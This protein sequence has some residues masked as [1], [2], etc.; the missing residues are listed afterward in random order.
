MKR[1]IVTSFAVVL[2][3]VAFQSCQKESVVGKIDPEAQKAGIM[4]VKAGEPETK[5]YIFENGTI[6]GKTAYDLKWSA[7]DAIGCYE[8]ST[9]SGT[10]TIQTTRVTSSPLADDAS[11][12]TFTMNFSGNSGEANFSYIFVYP[13]ASY[14]VKNEANGT[15][16]GIIPQKQTFALNSFDKNADL[17]ISEPIMNQ[18]S[19]PTDVSA[20]FERIGSTVLMNI[21]APG[22]SEKIRKITF[23]TSEENIKLQGYY[24]IRPLDGEY[25]IAPYSGSKSIELTPATETIYTGTIP[26]W[27]RCSETTLSNNFTVVVT[28]NKKIY[29]KTVDLASVSRQLAFENAGLTKFNVDMESVVGEDNPYLDDDDYIIVA[30]SGA[31]FYALTNTDDGSGKTRL[32]YSTLTD[33]DPTASAYYTDNNSIVW[34]LANGADN[35]TLQDNADNYLNQGD[36]KASVT[37]TSASFTLSNGGVDGDGIQRYKIFGTDSYKLCFNSTF[38]AFYTS[39]TG[40]YNLYVLPRDTRSRVAAPSNVDADASGSTI[41]VIWDDAVDANIDHYRVTLSGSA[42]GTQD[43]NPGVQTCE[44]TGLGDGT[45]TV[46][47]EAVP[48]NTAT[49]LNSVPQVV[50]DINVGSVVVTSYTK[51][52]SEPANWAGTYIIVYEESSTS[53]LVCIAGVDATSNYVSATISSSTISSNSLGDYEVEVTAYSTGYTMKALGGDNANKYLEGKGGSSNGTTFAAS[54]NKVTTFSI[55]EGKVTIT[56][57]TFIFSFNSNSGNLRWRFFKSTTVGDGSGAYKIPCLYKKN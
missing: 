56:N 13:A 29:S 2:A 19:R 42:D 34:T 14:T 32:A 17:L 49:H 46:T 38:F 53:G 51:V 30:Q 18:P 37:S 28:T 1:Q 55:S 33:F 35:F 15:Y 52:T 47:V 4:R 24:E 27:F 50:E 26:V 57:N 25:D 23:S 21:K 40:V 10:P 11:S 3:L 20:R 6:G 31:A 5:T 9:V 44:F 36:K 16:R 48:A 12:A 45:Y 43:V 41:T 8:V 54:S 7:G 39:D 22:T